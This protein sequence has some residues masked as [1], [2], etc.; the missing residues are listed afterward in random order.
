MSGD[1]LLSATK[2]ARGFNGKRVV[3]DIEITLCA[4]DVM[5]LLGPNGAGKSTTLK[6]LTGVLAPEHGSI[7]VCG[8]DLEKQPVLAKRHIGYL[9]EEAPLYV[10]LT[11]DEYLNYCATLRLIAPSDSTAAVA[12]VKQRCGLNDVGQRLIGKLS[13]G[14][15]QRIGIAQAIVH[16]PSV[17]VLDEP[18]NGLDPNQIRDVR[19]LVKEL[20]AASQALIISTHLL[21]E[22]QT[23]CDKVAILNRGSLCYNG[24]L[25]SLGDDLIVA[26]TPPPSLDFFR[27]IKGVSKASKV[28]ANRISLSGEDRR[29]ISREIVRYCATHGADLTELTSGQSH[30]EQLFFDLTCNDGVVNDD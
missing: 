26:I 13:K 3:H 19:I 29:S 17:L 9:P 27:Q 30:L 20:A 24:D 10:D 21:S 1:V 5:G 2:L 15:K 25:T 28:D 6:M 11:V 4:G 23:L 18:T 8:I 16:E 12:K 14:Y 7:T 22:V